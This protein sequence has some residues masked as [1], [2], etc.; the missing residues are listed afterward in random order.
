MLPRLQNPE[1]S[2]ALQAMI[3]PGEM[4]GDV[5]LRLS[6]QFCGR[7]RRGC[8]QV[9]REIGNGEVGLMSNG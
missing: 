6:D 4:L 5:V 2:R 3:Q 9:G 1:A 7:R 8:A